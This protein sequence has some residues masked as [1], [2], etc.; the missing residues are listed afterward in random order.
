MVVLHLCYY[1]GCNGCIHINVNIDCEAK[2]HIQSPCLFTLAYHVKDNSLW[3]VLQID[4]VHSVYIMH[5]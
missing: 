3:P 4:A 2:M 1:I 5:V